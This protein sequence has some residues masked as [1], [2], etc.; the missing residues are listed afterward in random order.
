MKTLNELIQFKM[1]LLEMDE[2]VATYNSYR[3]LLAYIDKH[4]GDIPMND[5][6]TDFC[7]RLSNDLKSEGKSPSTE[8]TYYAMLTAIWNY[9]SYKGYTSNEFPFQKHSYELDKVKKPRPRK[10]NNCFLTKEQ[11]T[12]IYKLWLDLSDQYYVGLF[13]ASYLSNG[14]NL[15]D[16]LRFKWCENQR[17][18]T[19]QRHKTMEK[20]DMVIKVPVIAP[21]E[22]I[23]NEIGQQYQPNTPIF[24]DTPIDNEKLIHK[25]VMNTNNK[26]TKAIREIAPTLNLPENISTTWARHTFSTVMHQSN[27]PYAYTEMALGHTLD[28]VASNYIGGFSIEDSFKFNKNL[29]DV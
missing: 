12:S 29:L 6:D 25:H 10:R 24:P 9:A 26:V 11:I 22:A 21:L 15:N 7:R 20:T 14:A 27:V 28:G 1:S 23:F 4:Y 5:V 3:T 18:I 2:K 13:L 19:F 17:L 16:V 8:R